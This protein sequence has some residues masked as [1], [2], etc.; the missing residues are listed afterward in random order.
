MKLKAFLLFFFLSFGGVIYTINQTNHVYYSTLLEQKMERVV[1]GS[2]APR[3]RILDC[4]GNVLVDNV[5][6]LQVAYHKPVNRT[7]ESEL[8]IASLLEPFVKEYSLSLT[9]LKNY[10]LA[11]H[12]NGRDLITEEEYRLWDERKLSNED[13]AA[14]KWERI[15]EEMLK[16]DEKERRI[17][18]L[19]SLMNEG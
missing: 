3:G 17:I 12:N 11:I 8:E 18:Y 14:L 5:G 4:N 15:T 16:F 2:S 10:Y 9:N 1:Y 19:F 6:V 7:I 13:I